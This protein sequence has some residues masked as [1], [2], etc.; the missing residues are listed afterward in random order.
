MIDNGISLL[1]LKMTRAW[2]DKR[3]VLLFLPSEMLGDDLRKG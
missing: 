3:E 2:D 1:R